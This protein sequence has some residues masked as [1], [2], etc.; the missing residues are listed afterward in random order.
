MAVAQAESVR[1]LLIPLADQELL[2]PVAMVAEVLGYHEPDPRP[3]HLADQQ[4]LLGFVT[5]RERKVPLISMEAVMTGERGEPGV[6]AQIVV[7]KGIDKRSQLPYLGVL[8]QQ[9][10]RLT[11]AFEASVESL[12]EAEPRPGI[13]CEVLANGQPALLPDLEEIESQLHTVLFG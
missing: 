3:D 5:W 1:C 6:R 9:L 8:A 12:D 4:W 2:L 7:V 10:P 11:T 13:H